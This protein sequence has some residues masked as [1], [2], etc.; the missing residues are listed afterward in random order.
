[1][2]STHEQPS[3]ALKPSEC[4]TTESTFSGNANEGGRVRST[5]SAA[6]HPK[7]F[8]QNTHK[9]LLPGTTHR[10]S[11]MTFACLCH[12]DTLFAQVNEKLCI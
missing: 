1:M 7:S 6:G 4:S 5:E 9:R 3:F 8:H 11:E 2:L 12:S 10:H